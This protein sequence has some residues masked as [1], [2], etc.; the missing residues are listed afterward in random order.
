MK[1][2]NFFDGTTNIT[3]M[4]GMVRVDM[5][6]LVADPNNPNAPVLESRERF[7]TPLQ[8]FIKMY[9]DFTKIIQKLEEGGMVKRNPDA[10]NQLSS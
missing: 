4:G 8:G 1:G 9:D 6:V 5:G 7:V 2:E 3:V 10:N